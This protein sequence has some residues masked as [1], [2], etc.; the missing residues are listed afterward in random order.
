MSDYK[1]LDAMGIQNPEEIARYE[2]YAMDQADVIRVTYNRKKG[3]ILPVSKKYR[4]AQAKKTVMV[5]SGTRE[6]RVIYESSGEFRNAADELSRLLG[7]KGAVG[8][9]RKL[10]A[11][12]IKLLEEDFAARISNLKSLLEKV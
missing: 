6:T 11:E 7:K 12:E 5:D 4:F 10:I 3:S 1:V 2:L 8:E 9:T